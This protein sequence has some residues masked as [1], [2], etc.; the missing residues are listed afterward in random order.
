MNGNVK[1]V[2]VGL[3]MNVNF[4]AFLCC[5]SHPFQLLFVAYGNSSYVSEGKKFLKLLGFL[6]ST[7]ASLKLTM[8]VSR[9]NIVV[10]GSWTKTSCAPFKHEL[11]FEERDCSYI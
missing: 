6:Q 5:G 3:P 4:K 2:L 8:D 7:S 1:A 11:T 9:G 10:F